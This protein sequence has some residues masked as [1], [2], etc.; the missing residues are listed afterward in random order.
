MITT[1]IDDD[2]E[3]IFEIAKNMLKRDEYQGPMA[4]VF[5]EKEKRIGIAY[6]SFNSDKEKSHMRNQ[7]KE[8]ILKND[9]KRY[10]T[11]FLAWCAIT[12]D[13]IYR[14][15]SRDINRRE[16]LIVTEYTPTKVKV[17]SQYFK[18]NDKEIVFEE[19]IDLSNGESIWNFYNDDEQIFAKQDKYIEKV[20]DD[21]Y[22]NLSK[23]VYAKFKD[24]M[25]NAKTKKE[26]IT[27]FKEI[28]EEAD[29]RVKDQDKTMLEDIHKDV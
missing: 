24:K 13:K 15:P 20:Y 8:Q 26:K 5:D 19:E 25:D 3:A 12:K 21:F 18:R 9:I 28:L 16:I 14:R 22:K 27:V 11:I 2:L 1:K 6:L 4:L 10:I 7:L 29:K 17:I 23:E